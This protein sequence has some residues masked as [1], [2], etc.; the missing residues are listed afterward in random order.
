MRI[1]KAKL[2]DLRVEIPTIVKEPRVNS[3]EVSVL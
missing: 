3:E 1:Q 2:V